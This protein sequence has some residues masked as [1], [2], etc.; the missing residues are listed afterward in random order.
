MIAV[1]QDRATR[2]Y[3]C[4]HIL[5]STTKQQTTASWKRI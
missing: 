1:P 3:S 4:C 2:R 5:V